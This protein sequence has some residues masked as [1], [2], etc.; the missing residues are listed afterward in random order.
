MRTEVHVHGT[1]LLRSGTTAAQIEEALRPWLE[2]IDED[3]LADVKSVHPDEPGIV[4]DRKRRLLEVCWTGDVGRSF[5]NKLTE[6]CNNL[7]P[8]TEY[9]SEVEVT[10]Y[11]DSGE[12]E[13]YQFFVGPSPEAIHE[14]RR[15]CVVEDINL[16]LARHLGKPEVEQVT[17]LVDLFDLGFA[18]VEQVTELVTRMF[19]AHAPAKPATDAQG[20]TG[21]SSTVIPLHPRNRHL[22]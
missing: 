12:D 1:I 2:Y 20:G 19:D 13:F 9:A 6:A 14:F 22:H 17:E 21:T 3:G 4:F 7:G 18:E 11:P 5:H 10:Y 8:L 16:M 15:Q